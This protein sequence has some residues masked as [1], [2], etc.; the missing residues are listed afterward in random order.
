MDGPGA[1]SLEKGEALLLM[2]FLPPSGAAWT[3]LT[4]ILPCSFLPGSD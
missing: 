3:L 4:L 2:P 1:T